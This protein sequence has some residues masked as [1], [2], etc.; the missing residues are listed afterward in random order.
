MRG[1]I[2]AEKLEHGL[3]PTNGHELSR[4]ETGPTRVDR[5]NDEFTSKA[6]R[7]S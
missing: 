6:E 5:I 4:N 7:L 2:L 1:A 3:H